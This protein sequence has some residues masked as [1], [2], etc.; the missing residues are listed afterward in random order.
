MPE[1]ADTLSPAEVID[2]S[3]AV[4]AAAWPVEVTVQGAITDVSQ[5][6][7]RHLFLKLGPERLSVVVPPRIAAGLLRR[8]GGRPN[9]VGVRVAIRGQIELYQGRELQLVAG[10]IEVL[11]VVYEPAQPVRVLAARLGPEGIFAQQ[12]RLD[13][14]PAPLRIAIVGPAG[15]GVDDVL[16]V[17][18]DSPWD[19]VIRHV[20]AASADPDA[21]VTGLRSVTDAADVVL[22]VRGGGDLSDTA[23]DDEAVVR[24]VA[25]CPV[26]VLTGIG[27]TTDQTLCDRAAA[28]SMPTPT[29][30]AR[31]VVDRLSDLDA[32]LEAAGQRARAVATGARVE[33][34]PTPD[35][36]AELHR[37]AD[38]VTT[39]DTPGHET[40]GTADEAVAR[41]NAIRSRLR[42]VKT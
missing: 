5:A 14:P 17:L 40:D 38:L 30:A 13:L 21:L 35:L 18:R 8:V 10:S 37:I 3:T 34:H 39:A 42:G 29:A 11:P 24:A 36:V 9:L 41:V 32:A 16:G 28:I 26:P 12:R 31:W 20:A 1:R 6:G 33:W 25:G 23:F 19:L 2:R 4:M 22:L 27:H 15:N 7:G